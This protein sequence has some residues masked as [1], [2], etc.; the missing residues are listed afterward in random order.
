MKIILVMG[1]PGVGKTTQD[2]KNWVP[3]IIKEIKK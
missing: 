1:L 3:K 2:E